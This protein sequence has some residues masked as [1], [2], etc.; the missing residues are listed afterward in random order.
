[1]SDSPSAEPSVREV[2]HA[3]VGALG[4]TERPGQVAMAEAVAE[5]LGSGRHLLVQAGTGTGK[6]L[7]Y[8]VPS[9]LHQDRVV[10]S[11]ATLGL[12]HQLVQRDLPAL[13]AGAREAMGTTPSYA[14]VKG[15][16]N[17]ACLHRV[18]EGVPDEQGALVDL[19][20][21]SL[22]AEVLALREWAE[23]LAGKPGSGDGAHGDRESAPSHTD[24][25]WRQVSVNHRECV[26]AT[27]CPHA[28]ECFAELARESAQHADVVVTN[29]ALLAIDAID[30]VPMLP[31]YDAVVVD[32]AHEL[33]ARV[34]QAATSDLDPAGIERAARRARPHT[35]GETDDLNEAADALAAALARVDVGRIDVFDDELAEALARVRDMARACLSAFPREKSDGEADASRQQAKAG[36]EEVRLVADRMASLRETEV[37]WLSDTR[38]PVLHVAP[39]DVSASLRDK[40][41]EEKTV[42]LT[43]AT[44][45]VGGGFDPVAAAVG[46]R[47]GD[48]EVWTGLDVGS[49]FDYRRQGIL[50][51]AKHLPPP[52]RDGITDAQLDEIA[53]L[54]ESAGGRTLGLFSSRRAAEAAAEGVR[55]RLTDHEILCQGDAQL[56]ELTRRFAEEERTS[57]FGTLSLWQGIDLPGDTCRLVIIDRVPFPRPDD[58]LMS[59]RQRLVEKRG[60]NGFMTVA[61]SHAALLLA[62]GSGRLIRRTT[63]RGVVA[64]LD[65]RLVTA[66]YGSFLAASLPPLWRTTDRDAVL[67]ALRRLDD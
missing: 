55:T 57:L 64:V 56:S 8:L 39:V 59:A 7:G 54:L 34:T 52:G 4:G 20:E 47:P 31:E 40:L 6:S 9:L 37:L 24:R 16:A 11:T 3:A 17:Y 43:S 10:V 62:Q 60:G 48:T 28:A 12:Q 36:L 38:G 51:V 25:A 63:D 49:P 14:V 41:F 33:A 44:L 26:G 35:D 27:R 15:R 50:Y 1:M 2:L 46:L 66:R 53:A 23:D 32:E 67:G 65:P 42:V 30:G 13:V 19:P 29:H 5:S 45:T 21:G 22:G 58:P 18:R 61:A